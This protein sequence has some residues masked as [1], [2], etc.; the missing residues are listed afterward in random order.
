[1]R[2]TL[3]FALTLFGASLCF[4]ADV[5]PSKPVRV[6]VPY[7][8]GGNTDIAARV[9]SRQLSEQLGKSF[10]VDN[11]AG[12][13]GAI[14]TGIVAKS[15]PDGYTLALADTSWAIVPS[16]YKSLSY[17]VLKDFIPITQI[18]R[19]PNVLV[20]SPSPN[21]NTLKEF[22]ALAQANPGKFVSL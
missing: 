20:V 13:T 22:I 8:P 9:I 15:A 11:R 3:L 12:A 10:I 19:V 5:Y 1:M 6:I 7:G 2:N 17:D 16:L 18:M 14:G 4:G 21:I